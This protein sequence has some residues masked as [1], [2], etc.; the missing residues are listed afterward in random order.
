M[1]YLRLRRKG[2]ASGGSTGGS[3][4]GGGGSA[5]FA[6]DLTTSSPYGWTS[7]TTNSN[8]TITL[9]TGVGPG[10]GNAIQFSHNVNNGASGQYNYGFDKVVEAGGISAGAS[11]FWRLK[12]KFIG[13]QNWGS[14]TNKFIADGT[15]DGDPS[16]VGGRWILYL[17]EGTPVFGETGN[18][19]YAMKNI[20]LD[21]PRKASIPADAGFAYQIEVKTN[22]PVGTANGY[23]KMWFNND[24]YSSPTSEVTG[25]D[26]SSYLRGGAN[27]GFYGD[28]I[29]QA[30][31]RV[32][33][34]IGGY[35][36]DDAFDATWYTNMG[37]W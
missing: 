37:S 30:G 36:Y 23:M 28:S 8:V 14:F 3:T 22:N 29:L 15:D 2:F 32:V 12:M 17:R 20:G 6:A 16:G 4:G 11:R 7:L 35:E 10:G 9:E 31:N 19:L 18:A 5:L 26:L 13:T 27:L 1:R 21:G 34:Q 25:M 24:N 33:Y